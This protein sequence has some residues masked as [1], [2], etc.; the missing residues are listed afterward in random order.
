VRIAI[1]VQRYGEEVLGGS[2]AEARQV[3]EH[4]QH[5]MQVEVLTTCALDMMTWANHYSPGFHHINGVPVRRFPVQRP[6]DIRRF[7]EAGSRAFALTASYLDQIIWMHLQGP[8]SPDL[9]N[10][11]RDH[12]ERY[13]LLVFMTY[14]YQTTFVGLQIAP[15]KS[16]LIPTA[17]DEPPVY[18]DIFRN[19][20]NLPRG[21]IY[22]T[23]DERDFVHKQF[24]NQYIPHAVLSVGIDI[25][26]L[27]NISDQHQ[28]APAIQGD[29]MLYMGR[30]DTSKGCDQLFDYFLTYKNQTN[31]PVKLVLTG[32]KM[33]P[34]PSHQDIL[35]LGFV[36]NNE[37]LMRLSKASL[38]V[39]PSSY[40]SLSISTLEAWSLGVPVLV[41][42]NTDVLR[43]HCERSQG[44]FFYRSR[45]EFV[46]MLGYLRAHKELCQRMGQHGKSYVME[47]YEWR[48]MIEGY[49][50]FLKKIYQ[51]VNQNTP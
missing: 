14:L 31:D 33:M 3:A 4:L 42:G 26:D 50:T 19:T 35:A 48:K 49:I 2:E 12:H 27:P 6:R 30:V 7:A 29:Y 17:H 46:E 45:I 39:H 8:D 11:I 9:T 24:R 47:H 13:D 5:Y 20:F 28:K 22:N 40:E 16:V 34:I 43:T 1:I 32:N 41:N 25:P 10:Y 21:I 37:R 36:D 51:L 23:S 44:G 38:Y 15:Q 18:M